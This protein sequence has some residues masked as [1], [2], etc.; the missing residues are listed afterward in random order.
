LP[1]KL[2]VEEPHSSKKKQKQ[3]KAKAKAKPKSSFDSLSQSSERT[4]DSTSSRSKF[5]F[6]A[7][8]KRSNKTRSKSLPLILPSFMSA[9]SQI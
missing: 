7:F 5:F 1:P 8:P 3:K 6:K 4:T 9:S 2:Q